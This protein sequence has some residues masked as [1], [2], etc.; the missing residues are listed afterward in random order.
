MA[1]E[2]PE[3]RFR[4][5]FKE[6]KDGCWLWEGVTGGSK[7]TYG[8]FRPGTRSS[9]KKILAHRYAYMIWI[10]DIPDGMEVHHL[11]RTPL[12]VRPSH[13]LIVTPQR[14]AEFERMKRCPE[15]HDLTVPENCL[16]DQQGRRRGCSIC[17]RAKARNRMAKRYAM[18]KG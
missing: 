15:G 14:N 12:C 2:A 1:A 4:R 6:E 17:H 16:W 13:L 11:C 8:Y 3:V 7:S 18:Q 9:D 5:F 10:G